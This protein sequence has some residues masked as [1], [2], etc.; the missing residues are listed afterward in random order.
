MGLPRMGPRREP[1][2]DACAP[3]APPAGAVAPRRAAGDFLLG[4]LKGM[5]LAIAKQQEMQEAAA[6]KKKK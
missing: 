5:G 6:K 4:G 3:H 2:A 1:E